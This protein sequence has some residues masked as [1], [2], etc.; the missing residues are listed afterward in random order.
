MNDLYNTWM[1]LT[2]PRLLVVGDLMLDRYTIGATER[3]SPEAPVLVLR[4][5]EDDVRP[6]GA[7]NVAS[8]LR[9]LEADVSLVG[10]V[11]DDGDGRTLRRLIDDGGIRHQRVVTVA[12]RPTTLKH[13]FCGRAGQRQ[14]HQLLRVDRE[15][16]SPI[17][18][19]LTVQLQDCIRAELPRCQAMLLS[20]YAK[21]MLT[22]ALVRFVIDAAWKSRVPVLIDPCRDTDYSR[23]AGAT[24]VAPNRVAAELVTGRKLH[25][26]E[27][28]IIAAEELR[29]SLQ[30]D[31]ALVTLDRDGIAFASSGDSGL[32]A[33]RQRTI[34]DVTGAGDMVLAMLGLC[35]AVGVPLRE[36]LE[37]A[38]TAAAL[39]VERFGVEPIS[40]AEISAELQRATADQKLVTLDRLA[41]LAVAHR[42][43]GRTVVFTNG[44][45][46]LLH[47]G[48]TT[49]L[50]EAARLGDVLIVAINSD[51]GVRRLK[52]ADRP[53]VGERD[54]AHMLA[55]LECVDHVLI[56]DDDTPHRLL[57]E[58]RPDVLVKGG[59]TADIVGREVVEAYGGRVVRLPESVPL[60]TTELL[61]Q[62]RKRCPAN[63]VEVRS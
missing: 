51:P 11:G 38:N 5:E 16:R 14:P 34:C 18:A 57:H 12:G 28:A 52:G 48:H 49:L 46:D 58:I 20:D 60:S 41:E 54:R 59:T 61:Q 15:D 27:T 62:I 22:P 10:V 7:A 3:V 42:R 35:F 53:V 21:G 23:Y 44:C 4:S 29:Q 56:F 13:R 50:Q 8:F 24:L 2:R 32:I 30:V 55:A 37:L 19:V 25:T 26:S 33:C 36:S 43:A 45:F 6:G 31:A 39:E 47:V 40:R 17:D 63:L 1:R 9:G